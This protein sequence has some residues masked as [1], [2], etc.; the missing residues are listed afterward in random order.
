MA[1]PR[2]RQA[3][4]LAALLLSSSSVLLAAPPPPSGSYPRIFLSDPVR[5]ALV[6][7]ASDPKS[8]MS[9]LVTQCQ[10]AAPAGSIMSSGYQGADWAMA[11]SACALA[12][13]ITG[14]ADYATTGLKF[15]KAMLE[16]IQTIGDKMACVAGAD[17]KAATASI[18]RDTDYAIR[19]I[20]PHAALVYDWLHD[21]P[22]VSS[23]FLQ[24]S[25]YCFGQ[26]I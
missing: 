6:K 15:W 9:A 14:T 5:A 26:W 25:R 23:D 18:R 7:A 8:G 3:G 22:G 10:K 19:Y 20:G 21:A 17:M 1:H 4:L 2:P 24:Q 11:G 16:D 12:Y 13:Q